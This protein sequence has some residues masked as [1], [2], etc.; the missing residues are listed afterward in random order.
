[1][2]SQNQKR[3]ADQLQETAIEVTGQAEISATVA[4]DSLSSSVA[5]FQKVVL[6]VDYAVAKGPLNSSVFQFQK[7]NP[8]QLEC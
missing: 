2:A 3:I 8:I 5:L 4:Q 6:P 1:M 7:V